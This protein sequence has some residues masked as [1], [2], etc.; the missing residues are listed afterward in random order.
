MSCILKN[1]ELI[2]HRVLPMLGGAGLSA[3]RKKKKKVFLFFLNDPDSFNPS[4]NAII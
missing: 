1:L 3:A 2:Q 4:E